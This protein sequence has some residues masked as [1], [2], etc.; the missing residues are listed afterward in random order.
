MSAAY[1]EFFSVREHQIFKRI[2]CGRI[3]LKH[4]VNMK[5]SRKGSRGMLPWKIFENLHTVV[6]ILVFFEHF[7][8]KFCLNLLLLNLSVSPNMMHFVCTF[9]I[10]HSSSM[11]LIVTEKVQNYGEIVFTK[12]MFQNG[13]WGDA[14]PTGS[15]PA[16]TDNNVT[17]HYSNQLVWLQH[18]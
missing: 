13:W 7:F 8:T 9:S 14:F 4:L 18:V 10:M 2:F 16:R 12:N 6:A 5:G 15:A 17:Y 11:R 1:S 3:I